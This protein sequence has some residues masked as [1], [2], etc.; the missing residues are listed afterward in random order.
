MMVIFHKCFSF[1]R[2]IYKSTLVPQFLKILYLSSPLPQSRKLS[3]K[4][5]DVNVEYMHKMTDAT[6]PHV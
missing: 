5:I 4:C 1:V 2:A 3:M 6:V